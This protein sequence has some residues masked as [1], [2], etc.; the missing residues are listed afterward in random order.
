VLADRDDLEARVAALEEEL[1]RVRRDAADARV[2]AGG[3]DR[4]V[5]AFM[6]KLDAHTELLN[7]LR[8]TQLEHGEQLNSLEGRF[9]TLEGRFGSL[10][11]RVDSLE[12]KVDSGFTKL[13]DGM[14]HIAALLEGMA[15]GDQ[16]PASG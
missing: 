9:G 2:L 3:V 15:G 14:A 10:E 8:E 6:A 5:A 11:R 13:G 4:D 16:T 1:R 12:H 7:A